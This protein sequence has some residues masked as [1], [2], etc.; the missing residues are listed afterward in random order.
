MGPR[1]VAPVALTGGGLDRPLGDPRAPILP[2][3]DLRVLG[4]LP[5]LQHDVGLLG[6][7]VH[8]G[9]RLR[10]KRHRRGVLP[11]VAA[12][13]ASLVTGRGL[14]VPR[15]RRRRED[16]KQC[17]TRGGGRSG[18]SLVSMQ[19]CLRTAWG[20]RSSSGRCVPLTS[21]RREPST[22]SHHCSRPTGRPRI[23]AWVPRLTAKAI[24]TT[25]T[26]PSNVK[27]KRSPAMSS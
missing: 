22:G 25:T 2:E 13:L 3:C 26:M 21:P 1:S 18:S 11:A 20:Y 16:P 27:T 6:G 9:V 24:R 10:R 4:C 8:V 5:R 15:M 12:G 7:Q 17:C 19:Q 23:T 14:R